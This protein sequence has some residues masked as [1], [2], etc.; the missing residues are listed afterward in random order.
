[1]LAQITAHQSEAVVTGW[2]VSSHQDRLIYADYQRM[3]TRLKHNW[4][5]K[6]SIWNGMH[7]NGGGLV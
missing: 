3:L 4:K 6:L 5:Q 2:K 7:F 1:V